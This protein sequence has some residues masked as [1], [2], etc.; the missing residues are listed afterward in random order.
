MKNEKIIAEVLKNKNYEETLHSLSTKLEFLENSAQK[1]LIE[2]HTEVIKNCSKTS[3][4]K[5][6]NNL[7]QITQKISDF[8]LSILVNQNELKENEEMYNKSLVLYNYL[9]HLQK[10]FEAFEESDNNFFVL[11]NL[12]NANI[13]IFK[14]MLFYDS[15][16]IILKQQQNKLIN[17]CK[18]QVDEWLGRIMNE[19][20]SFGERMLNNEKIDR[21]E[22]ELSKILEPHY[23]FMGLD[24]ED[25]FF[26]FVNWKRTQIVNHLKLK[27]ILGFLYI[28]KL[29]NNLN[30][31]F[32][33]PD[34]N[35]ELEKEELIILIKYLKLYRFDSLKIE[36][37]LEKMCVDFIYNKRECVNS[38]EEANKFFDLCV[39]YLKGV[40]QT[41]VYEIFYKCMDDMIL[42]YYPDN[43]IIN[44]IEKV[45]NVKNIR[46]DFRATS[47]IKR[48]E[49][50]IKKQ[51]DKI[52]EE[53]IYKDLKVILLN[54]NLVI[55]IRDKF[56]EN[57]K[58]IDI[59]KKRV[60]EG[61]IVKFYVY[62]QQTSENYAKIFYKAVEIAR[63]QE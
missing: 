31:K 61:E 48:M 37:R 28:E 52:F 47:R 46:Y 38:K 26:D 15:L 17:S 22:L 59:S 24:N 43:E 7:N 62:L 55:Y 2:N 6:K 23:I 10:I 25:E 8:S 42:N 5:L 30:K 40:D 29:L 57:I 27:Q 34:I 21:K 20:E 58:Q 35:I 11:K 19:Y 53:N 56:I 33:I 41:C 12:R 63:K 32:K 9:L 45:N 51:I 49:D 1:F 39:D 54:E 16:K 44:A 50:N 4:L 60:A 18:Q 13:K 36:Q 3:E 14:N